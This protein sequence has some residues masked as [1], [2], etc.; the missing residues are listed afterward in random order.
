[1]KKSGYWIGSQPNHPLTGEGDTGYG[2]L[3]LA[4]PYIKR[5]RS[6]HTV[7]DEQTASLA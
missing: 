3:Q 6:I 4:D 2:A 1:M 7:I 5:K